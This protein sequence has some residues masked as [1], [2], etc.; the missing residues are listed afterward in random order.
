MPETRYWP[1]NQ[2]AA[3]LEVSSSTLSRWA[4][5]FASFLSET[6][7][8]SAA[9]SAHIRYTDEDINVLTTVK[10]LLAEGL[11]YQ[12]VASHL[13]KGQ[14]GEAEQEVK[15]EEKKG[16]DMYALVAHDASLSLAPAMTALSDTLRTVMNGQQAILSS[17]QANRDLMGVVIQDNFNLKEENVKLRDRMLRLEQELAELRRGEDGQ[18]RIVEERLRQLEKRLEAREMEMRQ[19]AP[20]EERLEELE[21]IENRTG[22][23][24]SLLG[25]F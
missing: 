24:A 4:K 6:A 3:Q 15:E 7:T 14:Q 23:L 21:E 2:V 12:Q 18:H 5:E 19:P 20:P 13:E 11:A 1:A 9:D 22:C 8:H 16:G 10:D 17:Q 25:I